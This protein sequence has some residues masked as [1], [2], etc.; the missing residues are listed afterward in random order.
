MRRFY[1]RSLD[2]NTC[3]LESILGVGHLDF[4]SLLRKDDGR[5]EI[6]SAPALGEG[7]SEALFD[8]SDKTT[9]E[10]KKTYTTHLMGKRQKHL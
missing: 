1:Q 6:L 8:P 3:C 7:L 9:N 4:G 2:S 5:S 10:L